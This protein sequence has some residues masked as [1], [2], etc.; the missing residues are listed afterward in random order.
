MIQRGKVKGRTLSADGSSIG[1][2]DGN[3]ILNTLTYD[4]DF[5]DVDVRECMSNVIGK[6]IC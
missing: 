2:C 4:V 1:T 6:K 5:E 3:P